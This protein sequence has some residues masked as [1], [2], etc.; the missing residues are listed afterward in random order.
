MIEVYEVTED[1]HDE[2]MEHLNNT[3]NAIYHGRKLKVLSALENDIQR[4]IFIDWW[5]GGNLF[6]GYDK[7]NNKHIIVERYQHVSKHDW[8]TVSGWIMETISMGMG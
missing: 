8:E 3:A 6:N 4:I 5:N 2:V 1:N 7:E